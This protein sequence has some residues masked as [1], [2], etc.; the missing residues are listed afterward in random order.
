MNAEALV[1]RWWEKDW[2]QE[3]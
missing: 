1:R 3:E 2:P